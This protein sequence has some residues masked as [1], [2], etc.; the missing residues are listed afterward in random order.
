[1]RRRTLKLPLLEA[2]LPDLHHSD[3]D[4]ECGPVGGIVAILLGHRRKDPD[5]HVRAL[6]HTLL[7][8]HGGWEAER[9]PDGMALPAGDL[10]RRD[11]S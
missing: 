10:R 3:V 1:M 6:S 8:S 4:W 11:G 9:V 2:E 7:L 5:G